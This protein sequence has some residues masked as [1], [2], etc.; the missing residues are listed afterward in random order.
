MTSIVLQE[1]VKI[2]R[3]EMISR[4]KKDGVDSRPVFPTISKYP[5]EI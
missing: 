2:T 3:D 1:G 5:M 4:L